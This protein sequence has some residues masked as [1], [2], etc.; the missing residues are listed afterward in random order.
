MEWRKL[1]EDGY[2]MAFE[3]IAAGDI[4]RCSIGGRIFHAVV[5]GTRLGALEITAIEKGISHRRVAAADVVDHWPHR[6]RVSAD[7]EEPLHPQQRS[8]SDLWDR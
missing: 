2:F 4:V 7:A 1:R 5:R 3:D 8:L 6:S